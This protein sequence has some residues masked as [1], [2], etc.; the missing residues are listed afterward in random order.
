MLARASLLQPAAST[1]LTRAHA[2]WDNVE[3]DVPSGYRG[4]ERNS[5]FWRRIEALQ[6]T[7]R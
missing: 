3:G 1:A 2:S 5:Q 4:G 6:I 7:P